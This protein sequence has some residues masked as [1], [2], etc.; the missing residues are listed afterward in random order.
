MLIGKRYLVPYVRAFPIWRYG[1]LSS[2]GQGWWPDRYGTI[3]IAREEAE[4]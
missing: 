2:G 1:P 3:E 4:A